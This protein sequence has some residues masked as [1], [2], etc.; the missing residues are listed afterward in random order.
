M[1]VIYIHGLFAVEYGFNT[2]FQHHLPKALD[3]VYVTDTDSDAFF[4]TL[5]YSPEYGV[6]DRRVHIG[7]DKVKHR[8]HEFLAVFGAGKLPHHIVSVVLLV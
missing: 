2:T 8:V 1:L 7:A 5:L 6:H 3:V 4:S